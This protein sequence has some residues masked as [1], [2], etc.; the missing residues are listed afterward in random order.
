MQRPSRIVAHALVVGATWLI[1][2]LAEAYR[3]LGPN[4]WPYMRKLRQHYASAWCHA[5]VEP[6]LS[7][8][9]SRLVRCYPS[10]RLRMYE[11]TALIC[12]SVSLSL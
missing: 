4:C 11:T 12:A 7:P 8:L 5:Q 2:A 6:P 3:I 9:A 1:P 10:C